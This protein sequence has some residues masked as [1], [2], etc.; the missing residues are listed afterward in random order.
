MHKVNRMA[1][2]TSRLNPGMDEKERKKAEYE[3]K[4]EAAGE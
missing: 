2:E 1:R 4:K 3:K